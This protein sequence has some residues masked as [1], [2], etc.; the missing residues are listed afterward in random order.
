MALKPSPGHTL[1]RLGGK[2]KH[3]SAEVKTY[4]GA[5]TGKV[6][7]S[8]SPLYPV[9]TMVYWSELMAGN[10]IPHGGYNY[11]FIKTERIEGYEVGESN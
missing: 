3:V 5:T 11:V 4:E 10:P 6:M 9:G 2:Y 8:D 7:E 1:V